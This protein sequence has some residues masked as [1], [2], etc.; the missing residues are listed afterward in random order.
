VTELF[1]RVWEPESTPIGDL[2]IVH[3][4]AE[5]CGRYESLAG[6]MKAMGLRVH[7]YDHRGHGKSP[8]KRGY[9]RS[10]PTV[11]DELSGQ[12]EKLRASADERP[13]FLFAHSMGGLIG[14]N[15]L[16]REVEGVTGAII[17][18]PLLA[19]PEDVSPI[20]LGLAGVLGSLTPWLPVDRLES[21]SISRDQA[22]VDAYDTDPLVY[23]GPI[24]AR[25]GAQLAAGIKD[26]GEKLSRVKT[27]FLVIHGT[28]DDIAPP[29]GGQ[30]LFEEASSVDKS[31]H[32]QEGGYHELLNDLDRETVMSVITEW[33]GDRIDV[34]R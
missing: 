18:S 5:H 32:L 17:S 33:L 24:L 22:E 20:L 25:T 3:G 29:A 1:T 7:A 8:G 6:A 21:G 4:Y 30:R 16:T 27:P 13:L 14:A 2:L 19:V 28:D 12:I 23:R 9:I 11:V 26:T 31:I 34:A 10:F 15:L